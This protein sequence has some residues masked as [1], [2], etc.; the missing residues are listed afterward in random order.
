M[1]VAVSSAFEFSLVRAAIA[2][3]AVVFARLD[4]NPAVRWAA[5]LRI[6]P[7][8]MER[9]LGVKGVFSGM[10]EGTYQLSHGHV[11][12]ALQANVLTPVPA[13]FLVAWVATG[14]IPRIKNS[15]DEASAFLLILGGSIAVNLLN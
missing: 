4:H 15:R 13:L 14:Y 11:H 8:P 3:V 1:R 2:V 10:T 7:A 12:S 9:F 5:R 6:S